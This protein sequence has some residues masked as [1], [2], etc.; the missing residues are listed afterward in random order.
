MEGWIGV[1]L[2]GT[3]ATYPNSLGVDGIGDPVP[4]MVERVKNWLA[5]GANVRIVTA[6]V[7]STMLYCQISDRI[8]NTEFALAQT[9]L[10]E[11]WCIQH[12]GQKLPVTATKDFNMVVLYDDRAI[13]VECNTGRLIGSPK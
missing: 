7:A 4:R 5:L 6:R 11:D 1:D 12:I 13:Q 2:D 8:D 9:R 3:L 10:I